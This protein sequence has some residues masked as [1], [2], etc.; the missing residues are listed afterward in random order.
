MMGTRADFFIGIGPTA[1][2]IGSVS[3]DGWPDKRGWGHKPIRAR[4]EAQFRAAVEEMLST[5]GVTTT[6]PEEGWPWPWEDFRTSD[7]AYAWDPKRGPVISEF[8]HQWMTLEERKT[9]YG[10][11]RER[12]L[13]DDEVRDMSKGPKADV[14]AKSGLVL[15]R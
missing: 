7:W 10:R 12:K 4:S 5:T 1:E 6:R 2:W 15:L 9:S 3:H 14:W 8:G 11:E 13:R